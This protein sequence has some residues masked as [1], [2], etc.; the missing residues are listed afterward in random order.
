MSIIHRW[1][2]HP[3][4][5]TPPLGVWGYGCCHIEKDIFYLA[6]YCG[7]EQCYHNGLFC[8]STEMFV[9]N[10]LFATSET[11]GPMKKA[12]CALLPFHD[13][14]LGFGGKVWGDPSKTSSLAK[15]EKDVH[16]PWVYTNEHHLFDQKRGEHHLKCCGE[17]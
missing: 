12:Y 15:Y 11:T 2:Q 4:T 17:H 6:G 7:H 5:G 10:E 3:T 8:L 16:V 1:V 14:L 9:W 13:Q